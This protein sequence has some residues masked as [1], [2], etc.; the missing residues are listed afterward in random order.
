MPVSANAFEILRDCRAL[1]TGRL[2]SLLQGSGQLSN[3]AITAL[4]EGAGAYFDEITSGDYRSGF[5]EEAH[6][7]TS[8]R[9]TLLAEDDLEIGIRFD[10][11]AARL[12]E[13]TGNGLWKLHLRFVTL[14]N[15]PKL[16][17]GDNPVGPK[18]I[19]RGLG[20]MF[21]AA[22]AGELEQ[23]LA[24][25]DRL[26]SYLGRNLPGLYAE[27]N[28]FLDRRG[29]EAAQPTIVT[30]PEGPVVAKEFPAR[31]N[32]ALQALQQTLLGDLPATPTGFTP[33]SLLS[34][35]AF[36]QLM[37]RLDALERMGRGD[38]YRSFS[39]TPSTEML[40]PELFAETP[41]PQAPKII[42]SAELGIPKTSTESLAIDTL[43]M[44]FESIFDD[45]ELPEALKAAASSL[46]IKLLKVAMKDNT[47]FSDAA[48]PARQVID[49]MGRAVL[50]LPLDVPARHPICRQ[51]FDLASRLRAEQ[52]IDK[53]VFAT[54][55]AELDA[56]IAQRHDELQNIAG[57]YLPLFEQLDRREAIAAQ[58]KKAIDKAIDGTLP[59]PIRRF[60]V[61]TWHR[62]LLQ[63]GQEF[64]P[65]S[66]QWQACSEAVDVLLS[67][68][69]P[70][71]A[72]EGRRVLPQRLP[73]ALKELKKGMERIGLP[74]E[75]QEAFFDNCFT[76]QKQAL[77][78]APVADPARRASTI[79]LPT[80]L[81]QP[82]AD[83]I[84][85]GRL[86]LSVLDFSDTRTVP[87][88]SPEYAPG[89]WLTF[90][91]ANGEIA[92]GHICRISPDSRRVLLINPDSNLFISIHPAILD[93]QMRDGE[94]DIRSRLSLFDRAATRAL[95]HSSP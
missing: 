48:H 90:R 89:D 95:E 7:L 73:Q 54:A 47:L 77:L 29:V 50:G 15:R 59:E 56:L 83:E 68:V 65:D 34:Q 45:P 28:D 69:Q 62:V 11:L 88:R 22:G 39:S 55:V 82:M 16:P 91:K 8:S 94:A 71:A 72:D 66:Q 18:S 4:E 3:N 87:S 32:D 64:G 2:G 6:G 79:D 37:F 42:R 58:A 75:E 5:A 10:N 78:T 33:G 70:K 44:I 85:T 46:Q 81:G 24:L 19:I 41:S 92:I 67:S 14:L 57:N 63:V 38:P 74:S 80:T 61:Q 12:F 30:A 40:I 9:I 20:H 52:G 60:L 26:E 13:N 1:F 25:L 51:L 35:S 76:L 43:A 36:E 86:V 84:C 31:Q 49:R 23:K 53:T 17:K 21:A 27:L 93:R